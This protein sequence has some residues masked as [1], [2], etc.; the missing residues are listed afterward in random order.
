MD[1]EAKETWDDFIPIQ[2]TSAPNDEEIFKALEADGLKL[3]E[4]FMTV[5]D[6]FE[7]Q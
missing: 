4:W 3:G 6:P 2:Q 1:D 7:N 5:L